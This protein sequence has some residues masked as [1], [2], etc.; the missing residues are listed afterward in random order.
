MRKQQYTSPGTR[1]IDQMLQRLYQRRLVVENLI[2][3]LQEYSRSA[4][5]DLPARLGP[6]SSPGV[7]ACGDRVASPAR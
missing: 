6:S 7:L 1:N 5:A 4:P 3:L 2:A